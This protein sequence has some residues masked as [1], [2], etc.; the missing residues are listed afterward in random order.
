MKLGPLYMAV[1]E[2]NQDEVRKS[3]LSDI[4][5]VSKFIDTVNDMHERMESSG[6]RSRLGPLW[7]AERARVS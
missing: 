7:K 3:M 1:E 4:G 2:K 5:E 6:L